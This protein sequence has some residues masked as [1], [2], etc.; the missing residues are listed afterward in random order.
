MSATVPTAPGVTE[1]VP[2]AG[3]RLAVRTTGDPEGPPV[4]LVHGFPDTSAV[5]D[6]LRALLD[7]RFQVVTY[8]VRGAGES[9]DPGRDGYGL[10]LLVADLEAVLDATV[11]RRPVHLVGHDW[12]S[13]QS[14]EAVLTPRLASRFASFTSICGPPLDH[15]GVRL[16]ENLRGG[17]AG[18]RAGS[19]QFV[20]SSYV[21]AFHL[22]GLPRLVGAVGPEGAD[23]LRRGWA[24]YLHRVE[25]VGTDDRWPAPTFARDAARGMELYRANIR[26]RLARPRQR[27]T[28]VA[29]QVLVAEHDRYIA[30]STLSGLERWAERFWWRPVPYGHWMVRSHPEVVA[31][32]VTELA[33]HLQGGPESPALAA[34]RAR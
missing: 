27:T 10:D 26:A 13:I 15:V 21:Y 20:R 7:E 30:P 8:D 34:G 2:G 28:P 16:R 17:A 5:W 33:D 24:G 6:P 1:R 22:P 12:G 19:R 9:G 23:R 3:V 32:A 25:G 18:L 31:A 14:W 4:L 11:G 29:V